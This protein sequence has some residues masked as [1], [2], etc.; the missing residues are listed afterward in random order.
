MRMCTAKK[1]LRF[2]IFLRDT[3]NT[4][5]ITDK[6]NGLTLAVCYGMAVWYGMAVTFVTTCIRAFTCRTLTSTMLVD[7][8]YYE[9]AAPES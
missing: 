9:C 4:K 5:K 1:N 2:R 6:R 8:A 3:A 7:D